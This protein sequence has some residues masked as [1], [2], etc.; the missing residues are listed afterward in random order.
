MHTQACIICATPRSGSTLLCDLLTETGAAGQPDSFFRRQSISWWADNLNVLTTAW[1][2]DQAFDQ[3]YLDAV[4]RQGAAE[5]PVFSLRLM[6]ESVCDLS[7]RLAAIF[8]DLPDDKA[9][10][11][12]VFGPAVHIHLTRQDKVAQAVSRLRAEQSGLWHIA[13][14]GSERERLKQGQVPTYDAQAISKYLTVLEAHDAAWESWFKRHGIQPVRLTY[15]TLSVDPQ[16]A[17]KTVLSALDLDPSIAATVKP[18]TARMAS[19]E[20]NEWVGRFRS[21]YPRENT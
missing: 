5:T 16:L 9:R 4:L 15:E 20:S 3:A 7:T 12:S 17:L 11:F 1:E 2:N 21:E 18:K 6:W 10:L 8:P 14:D 13:S 19:D